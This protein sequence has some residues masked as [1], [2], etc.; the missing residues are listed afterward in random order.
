MMAARRCVHQA[1]DEADPELAGLLNDIAVSS[2]ALRISNV[3]GLARAF[4]QNRTA[5]RA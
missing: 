2:K 1:L 5:T 3:S 4:G